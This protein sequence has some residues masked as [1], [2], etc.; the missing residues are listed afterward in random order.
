MSGTLGLQHD[1]RFWLQWSRRPTPYTAAR[2]TGE[3]GAWTVSGDTLRLRPDGAPERT[4]V[5][6]FRTGGAGLRLTDDQ[7]VLW[8]WVLRR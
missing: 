5:L 2:T 1:G 3:D 7:G 8:S 6:R 4:L